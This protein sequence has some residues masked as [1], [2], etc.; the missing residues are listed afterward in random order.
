MR[1][2][3]LL[4]AIVAVAACAKSETDMSES[5]QAAMN[6]PLTREMLAGTWS[7]TTWAAGT[8]SVINRWTVVAEAESD[9]GTMTPEGGQSVRFSTVIDGDSM[10]VTSAPF[11]AS[12]A[13][14][15]PMVTFRSVGRMVD[16]RLVGTG[17]QMLVAM[18]DSVVGRSHWEAV[19]Q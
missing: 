17:M 1:K 9:S 14:D 7:G 6:P 11:P 18:P 3:F 8:D 13:A 4:V 12:A 5:T 2:T 19:K 16:G 15:A 10:I